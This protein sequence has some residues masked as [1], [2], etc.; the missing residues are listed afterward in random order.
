EITVEPINA[1]FNVEGNKVVAFQSS[2]DGKKIDYKNLN[3]TIKQ[4]TPEIVLGE[5][6][7]YSFAIPILTVE[8]DV[9]TEEANKFGIVEEIGRGKSYFVGSSANRIHNVSLAASRINGVLVSP[10]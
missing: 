8:P 6:E 7:K 2:R 1:L 3:K 5:N 10:G 9:T 4:R